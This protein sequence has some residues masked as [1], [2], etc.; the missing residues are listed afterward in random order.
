MEFTTYKR[1]NYDEL[2]HKK[3]S[4]TWLTRSN[5]DEDYS[6]D[7]LSVISTESNLSTNTI[8]EQAILTTCDDWRIV[9]TNSIAQEELTE[10]GRSVMDIIEPNFQERLKTMIIERRNKLYNINKRDDLIILSG[11]M[12][13][14]IKLDGTRS[15][16]LLWLKEKKDESGQP[17][18][19]IW[20]FEEQQYYQ[21][22]IISLSVNS[23]NIIQSAECDENTIQ[24]LYDLNNIADI[25]GYSITFLIPSWDH[26][27]FYF[28]SQT[29][30]GATFPV[31]VKKG[32]TTTIISMPI[33]AGLMILDRNGII[34][35]GNDTFVKSLFGFSQQEICNRPI[36]EFLLDST[37]LFKQTNM[38]R[39]HSSVCQKLLR[40]D[41]FK[42]MD[43][44]QQLIVNSQSFNFF[45]IIHRDRTRFE[46]QAELMVVEDKDKYA[47]WI[48]FDRGLGFKRFNERLESENNLLSKNGYNYPVIIPSKRRSSKVIQTSA[49]KV[50]VTSSI[51]DYVILDHL[52]EGAY[53][54]VKSAIRK[55]DLTQTKVVIKYVIKSRIL[56][57]CWARD[58]KLGTVPG[59]IHIL[60]TLR[61]SPHENLCNMLDY[62][63]DADNYYIVMSL[64][65]D[66]SMD[67][68][69]Y[70]ELHDSI[71][72]EDIRYIFKQTVLGV[73]H[74]HN[75]QIVH[76]DIKDE[77]III[78]QGHV[79]LIDFGSA[80][81]I[82]P[83]KKFET[84]VGTLE[85]AAPE[86]LQGHSYS[87]K[88]QDIW[89]LGI[90]LFTLVHRETPFY[91]TEQI[92]EKELRLPFV[93]T[94]GLVDLIRKMLERDVDK[95]IDIQQVLAHPWLNST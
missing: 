57:D 93:L 55:D 19:F 23:D 90:L 11:N 16:A 38:I 56:V 63:E 84:F 69:D 76:R 10:V 1:G 53:G 20:I 72:E 3:E 89:A 6:S 66:S 50:R 29:K 75:N 73:Q 45:W 44:H 58:R 40:M 25:V 81:Y 18:I 47:V 35:D 78:S 80:A 52:G 32:D 68:F 24:E 64:Y 49:D 36:S 14:I 22:N 62:F 26:Y 77:N 92:M 65:G 95:R 13:P 83:H 71:P 74:L 37:K 70:I 28:G 46:V 9:L 39:I 82:R 4:N 34:K 5:Y 33:I 61:N 91:N 79:Q 67:L 31:M 48:S 2:D 12:V 17:S 30:L 87:G 51:D 8:T 43:Q 94:E 27:R 21:K 88:P 54:V 42:E 86:V 41:P 15:S 60:N 59:E 85:Y 7:K